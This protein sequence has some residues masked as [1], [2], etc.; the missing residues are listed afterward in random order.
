M[1]LSPLERR[2]LP[3][4]AVQAG[5]STLVGFGAVLV[6]AEG[7]IEA[8]VVYTLLMLSAVMAGLVLVYASGALWRV[9]S[10]R[11]GMAAMLL[12]ASVLPFAHR[13]PGLLALAVGGF[14]GVAWGAR[15]WIE[16]RLVEDVGR[17]TYAAH[18]TVTSVVVSLVVMALSSLWLTWAGDGPQTARGLYLGYAA[19]ASVG[20]LA[21]VHRLP[22]TPPVRLHQP[23]ALVRQAGWRASMR[24][25]GLSSVMFAVGTVMSA[26]G[27]MQALGKASHYGWVATLATLAGA[28]GLWAL[29]HRRHA[30]NRVRTMALST[31]GLAGAHLMLGASAWLPALYVLHLLM[32]AG[33][34]PF[35]QASEQV[36]HQRAMDF[37]GELSD[38][39]A[40]REAGLWLFRM[41]SLGGFWLVM[42]DA[43]PVV[44]LATGSCLMALATTLE[45]LL[46][47]AWLHRQDVAEARPA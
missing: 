15:H 2:L 42:H 18:V 36:L 33:I 21:T 22:D 17:D 47:R 6:H 27:A 26:S 32:Q 5:L 29:R 10:R 43:S 35:W 38:R 45:F 8:T 9:D 13:H 25:Y 19:L 12:A 30:G 41:I 46:G 31:L 7:G 14:I 34:S 16:L 3:Y 23:W 1:Q 24:L 37:H 4:I 28:A 11:M 44:I 39:I 20:A 40:M